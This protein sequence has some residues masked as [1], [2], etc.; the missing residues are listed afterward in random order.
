MVSKRDREDD[1]GLM[2]KAVIE[3]DTTSDNV[4]GLEEY[5]VPAA[6]QD[7]DFSIKWQKIP[8]STG[9]CGLLNIKPFVALAR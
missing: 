2:Y 9:Q 7:Y 4:K 6:Y 3:E 5:A 1:A 8:Q